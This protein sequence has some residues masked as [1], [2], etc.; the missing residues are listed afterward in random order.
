M[1]LITDDTDVGVGGTLCQWQE[2]NPADVAWGGVFTA[3]YT[4]CKTIARG[5]KGDLMGSCGWG[6]ETGHWGM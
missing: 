4:Q 1:I 6:T 5:L 2:V 3:R